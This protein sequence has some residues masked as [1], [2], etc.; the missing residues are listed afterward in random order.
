M[1][2]VAP[3]Q[4]AVQRTSDWLVGQLDKIARQSQLEKNQLV[5]SGRKLTAL[6]TRANDERDPERA[7]WMKAQLRPVTARH[8]QL[9]RQFKAL[10][11]KVAPTLETARKFLAAVGMTAA[12][13][14]ALGSLGIA[15]FIVPAAL[16][17]AVLVA[18]AAVAWFHEAQAPHVR[19][20]IAVD[21]LLADPSLTNQQRGELI[22][23]INAELNRKPTGPD[24]LGLTGALEALVPVLLISGS[25]WIAVTLLQGRRGRRARGFA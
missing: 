7:G 2:G 12:S 8:D 5:E 17:A 18:W 13:S 6:W 21:K 15:Q 11:A 24:P 25:I 19:A 16:V 4:G 9:V 14:T 22:D 20:L 3:Y 23:A 1:I 10:G